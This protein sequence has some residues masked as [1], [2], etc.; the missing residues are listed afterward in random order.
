MK[1]CKK[2]KNTKTVSEDYS[3]QGLNTKDKIKKQNNINIKREIKRMKKSKRKAI[4]VD[5]EKNKNVIDLNANIG[6]CCFTE[7]KIIITTKEDRKPF[8]KAKFDYKYESTVIIFDLKTLKV[9]SLETTIKTPVKIEWY[10]ERFIYLSN[11]VIYISMIIENRINIIYTHNVINIVD[12]DIKN[13]MIIYTDGYTVYIDNI[14]NNEIVHYKKSRNILNCCVSVEFISD[15]LFYLVTASGKIFVLNFEMEILEHI[16]KR[17]GFYNV[18]YSSGHFIC[19]LQNRDE[20]E[21]LR[22]YKC[23]KLHEKSVAIFC[24][25]KS[26][27]FVFL[28]DVTKISRDSRKICEFKGDDHFIVLNAYKHKN[29]IYIVTENGFI[30]INKF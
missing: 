11:G 17:M 26:V 25:K 5:L 21:V 4:V 18:K 2:R 16:Q 8:N 19:N 23:D 1:R 15:D 30:Y 13:D 22:I 3:F 27:Y 20:I 9:T 12:F 6:S 28:T 7:S 29:N 14:S 10:K 24:C